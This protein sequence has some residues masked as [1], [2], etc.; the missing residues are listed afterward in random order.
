MIEMIAE[1]QNMW[2]VANGRMDFAP[3]NEPKPIQNLCKTCAPCDLL[4]DF[5]KSW[6]VKSEF[7]IGLTYQFADTLL[8]IM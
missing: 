2:C 4:P 6:Q 7:D 8:N 3:C 1:Q 5:K